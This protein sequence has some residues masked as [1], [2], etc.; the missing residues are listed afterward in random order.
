MMA[1]S[2]MVS[3]NAKID[4]D[5]ADQI[6]AKYQEAVEVLEKLGFF[7]GVPTADAATATET[8]DSA[9]ATTEAPAAANNFS[10]K[11]TLTRAQLAVMLF[12]LRTGDNG[13]EEAYAKYKNYKTYSDTPA[14]AAVHINYLAE[15][16][17][18]HGTG[19]GKFSPD[20]E[21]DGYQ[22]VQA[23]LQAIGYGKLGEFGDTYSEAKLQAAVLGSQK[24]ITTGMGLTL[25][26]ILTREQ[27]AGLIFNALTDPKAYVVTL[28]ADGK[29]YVEEELNLKDTVTLG[30]A[31]WELHRYGI[32]SGKT[33]PSDKK[34]KVENDPFGRPTNPK[35][36][37]VV[38]GQDEP[39]QIGT[40]DKAIVS[41]YTKAVTRSEL[42][43]DFYYNFAFKDL[44]ANTEYYV[45]GKKLDSNDPW[46]YAYN[47]NG[48]RVSDN[49]TI[50]GVGVTVEAY[51]MADD[52]VAI[53]DEKYDVG[54]LG[55][56]SLS[57]TNYTNWPRMRVVIVHHYAALIDDAIWTNGYTYGTGD[58]YKTPDRLYLPYDKFSG[59]ADDNY[60]DH[61]T[62]TYIAKKV[63]LPLDQADDTYKKGDAIFYSVAYNKD[64]TFTVHE[65]VNLTDEGCL[66]QAPIA[67]VAPN[68]TYIRL[69]DKDQP[70]NYITYFMQYTTTPTYSV[71]KINT[72][73]TTAVDVYLDPFTK[74]LVALIVSDPD[75][76]A[77]PTYSDDY[78][79]V[80]DVAVNV[81][82]TKLIDGTVDYTLKFVATAYNA[83]TGAS[84]PIELPY[85]IDGTN[86]VLTKA[87][88]V[89]K[90]TKIA[91]LNVNIEVDVTGKVTTPKSVA[92]P[93]SIRSVAE[94][95]DAD[96]SYVFDYDAK[97]YTVSADVTILLDGNKYD[98]VDDAHPM[99]MVDMKTKE[100]VTDSHKNLIFYI[101]AGGKPYI[102]DL[103]SGYETSDT[104]AIYK[105]MATTTVS[106]KDPEDFNPNLTYDAYSTY[107]E[108]VNANRAYAGK[109]PEDIGTVYTAWGAPATP[110][111]VVTYDLDDLVHQFI[112][113]KDGVATYLL[114][115]D[116]TDS[117]AEDD[118][119]SQTT[120]YINSGIFDKGETSSVVKVNGWIELYVNENTL[121]YSLKGTPD[122]YGYKDIKYAGTYRFNEFEAFG[123]TDSNRD[124]LVTLVNGRVSYITVI[125]DDAV[126]NSHPLSTA[127]YGI[128]CGLDEIGSTTVVNFV[129]PN[130]NTM[131]GLPLTASAAIYY[132]DKIKNAD[133]GDVLRITTDSTGKTIT[134]IDCYAKRGTVVEQNSNYIVSWQ[135]TYDYLANKYND[136]P[137]KVHMNLYNAAYYYVAADYIER[138]NPQKAGANDQVSV[139]Q[140]S[141]GTT[142]V[143]IY[144]QDFLDSH[145]D[146]DLFYGNI[147][148]FWDGRK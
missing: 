93:Y 46:S 66:V 7:E 90:V 16:D 140:N 72:T 8:E 144:S 24:G 3:A 128:Y 92:A 114:T 100:F 110:A 145:K 6:D 88:D 133:V 67:Q 60:L 36:V 125:S 123:T 5:D 15:V 51:M 17:A 38:K 64:G 45:D 115:W 98:V 134:A 12:K 49:D 97:V 79:Y 23:L 63:P 143:V 148:Q 120:K 86:K 59:W 101:M 74:S 69:T 53:D 50:G 44:W 70:A 146:G 56:T 132:N 43:S 116:E 142:V 37:A 75:P 91:D 48:T 111:P 14:W 107:D 102:L 28:K 83:K 22:A 104:E 87:T 109:R 77:P 127:F 19:N 31:N 32:S 131:K 42:K 95:A 2:L 117:I 118:S 11:L 34:I 105:T 27:M 54:S 122:G 136:V 65:D 52:R 13:T 47:K 124:V 78:Y 106:V 139:F 21:V 82:Q 9:D 99:V 73:G 58:V 103:Y 33:Y 137:E 18:M 108:L 76:V 80:T 20:L 40:E 130:T 30:E 29:D 85:E 113:Y 1:V 55:D 96:D 71:S 129:D 61:T 25:S 68:R 119:T 81:G 62:P 39:V 4:F 138:V 26:N 57:G 147:D 41:Y 84:T 10:P 112:K 126:E 135:Y 35:W 141:N 121:V 89:W 94:D